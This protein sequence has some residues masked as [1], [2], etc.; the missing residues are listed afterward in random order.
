MKPPWEPLICRFVPV[1]SYFF[2]YSLNRIENVLDSFPFAVSPAEPFTGVLR[3]SGLLLS[4]TSGRNQ[5]L[6][7]ATDGEQPPPPLPSH[8]AAP[9]FF[10]FY[11]RS[12]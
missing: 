9:H 3:S 5:R 6:D 8:P 1:T 10:P 12:P 2:P 4:L 11:L 7:E